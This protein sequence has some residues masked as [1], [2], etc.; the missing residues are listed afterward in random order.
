MGP[1]P[2]TPGRE[3]ARSG[4]Q[5]PWA[6]TWWLFAGT[7]V[8]LGAVSLLTIGPVLLLAGAVTVTVGCA[9]RRLRGRSAVVAVAGLAIPVLYVAW[10]N[11]SGPGTVCEVTST[12]SSCVEEW[13]PWPFVGVAVLLVVACALVLR[14]LR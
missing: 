2:V 3:R 1:G 14:K 8:G 4:R 5:S 7:L 6:A 13:S 12:T 11:R 10:L 9:S